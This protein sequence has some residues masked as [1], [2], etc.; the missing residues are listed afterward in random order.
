[1]QSNPFSGYGKPATPAQF[2]G[3]K[4]NLRRIFD[5][6]SQKAPVSIVGERRIGKTSLLHYIKSPQALEQFSRDQANF[7]FVGLE[8]KSENVTEHEFWLDMLRGLGDISMGKPWHQLLTDIQRE[9]IQAGSEVPIFQIE[10]FFHRIKAWGYT[11]VFLL[12][13]FDRV[14]FSKELDVHFFNTI[15][16]FMVGEDDLFVMVVA[17]RIDLY[18]AP[19]EIVGSPFF[20]VFS[21]EQLQEFSEDDFE[22]WLQNRLAGTNVTFDE[23]IKEFLMDAG[24]LHPFFLQIIAS[25]VFYSIEQN[26]QISLSA[27]Q[28]MLQTFK[29]NA[30]P[31][32]TY[33]WEHSSEEEKVWLALLSLGKKSARIKLN[34]YEDT[35]LQELRKRALI[36]KVD[37]EYQI[38]SSIFSLMVRDDVY[39]TTLGDAETYDKFLEDFKSGQPKERISRMAGS[40][41]TALLNI[42]PKYWGI[43]LHFLLNK[44]DPTMLLTEVVNNLGA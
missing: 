25:E 31:H 20:N 39:T 10:Q 9:L 15:R 7:L 44:D 30:T 36:R 14:M 1:M 17:S 6:I 26:S 33:Y 2:C 23:T 34:K 35:N 21:T 11:P 24:G 19:K 42:N 40:A 37:N 12:D 13:E 5:R 16:S 32:F 28:E 38:F 43:F 27:R 8:L 29:Q 22:E 18:K 3:R 4:K 41:K